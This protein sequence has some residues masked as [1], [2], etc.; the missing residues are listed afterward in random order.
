MEGRPLHPAL[1]RLWDYQC[2]G[3]EYE[4]LRTLHESLD[5][6]SS[7]GPIAVGQRGSRVIVQGVPLGDNE[8]MPVPRTPSPF[9][10]TRQVMSP[11]LTLES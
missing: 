8:R 4:Q 1:A 11:E 7:A 6:I 9:V 3:D 10:P 5:C 2:T